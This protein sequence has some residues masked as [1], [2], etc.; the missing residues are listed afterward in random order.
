MLSK[1][2]RKYFKRKTSKEETNEPQRKN[3]FAELH[4]LQRPVMEILLTWPGAGKMIKFRCLLETVSSILPTNPKFLK[5][6][7]GPIVKRDVPSAVV[8]VA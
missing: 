2:H 3:L 1:N 8:D 4:R 5:T 7:D 6:N